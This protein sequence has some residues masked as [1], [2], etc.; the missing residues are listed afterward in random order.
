MPNLCVYCES[1]TELLEDGVPICED[2]LSSEGL[3]LQGMCARCHG[4]HAWDG[5]SRGSQVCPECR[6]GDADALIGER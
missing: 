3:A 1:P 5:D 6:A 2:C 4:P